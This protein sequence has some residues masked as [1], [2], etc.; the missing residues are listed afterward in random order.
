VVVLSADA[1]PGIIRRLLA[2]GAISCLSKPLG[3]AQLDEVLESL[4]PLLQTTTATVRPE[5]NEDDVHLQRPRLSLPRPSPRRPRPVN[6]TV[7]YIEDYD[8]AVRLVERL[9]EA[10]R[11]DTELYVAMNAGEGIKTA[12]DK[13]PALILLDNHLPDATGIEVLSRL[14][15][16]ETTAG[17]PVVVLSGDSAS[18]GE[19]LLA[20]GASE[21]LSKPFDIYQLLAIIDRY[22]P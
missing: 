1:T 18:I 20:A 5:G 17:I 9:L 2:G 15:A 7:L 21:F 12:T 22:I 14:A 13:Q 16:S 4:P 10:R 6:R 3:L 8:G 19:E 11:P